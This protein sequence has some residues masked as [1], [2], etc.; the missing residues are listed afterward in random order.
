MIALSTSSSAP[1]AYVCNIPVGEVQKQMGSSVASAGAGSDNAS[2]SRTCYINFYNALAFNSYELSSERIKMNDM[3]V[4]QR[5]ALYSMIESSSLEDD[6]IPLSF[7][8]DMRNTYDD[9]QCFGQIM[10]IFM[11]AY[12]KHDDSMIVKTLRFMQNFTYNEIGEVGLSAT[13]MSLLDS[14]SINV[15]S[16]ALSLILLWKASEFKSIVSAYK[17]PK[18]AFINIK[19]KKITS[20]YTSER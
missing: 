11:G 16:S 1:M 18:D 6:S 15:Q 19:M 8:E 5:R 20:W 14:K 3:L 7:F 4:N 9:I 13:R 2:D 10:K 17:S 12:R